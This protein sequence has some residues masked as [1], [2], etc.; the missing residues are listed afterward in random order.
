[1][2]L[3]ERQATLEEELSQAKAKMMKVLVSVRYMMYHI[4][5]VF[6][7]KGAYFVN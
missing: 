1:M 3:E 2:S 6:F 7:S 4:A 5:G